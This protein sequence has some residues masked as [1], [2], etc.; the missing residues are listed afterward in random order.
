MKKMQRFISGVLSLLIICLLFVNAVPTVSGAEAEKGNWKTFEELTKE[1]G[2]INGIQQP[3]FIQSSTG[4]D[5]GK[6]I[7]DGYSK[8]NFNESMFYEVFTNSKAMGFEICKLWLTYQFGGILFDDDC[9]VVGVEPTYLKNLPRVFEIAEEC[10]IYLCITLVNHFENATYV[11]GKY[12]HEEI[13]Q[14]VYNENETELFIENFA[15]PILNITKDFPNIIMCDIFCEPESNGGRWGLQI[16]TSWNNIVK[17]MT[18]LNKTV[19]QVNPRL[20]TFSSASITINNITEGYYDDIGL[21]CYGFDYYSSYGTAHKTES[22]FLDAP[23]V[24]GEVGTNSTNESEEYMSGF[25]SNY[26]ETAAESGVKA[27]FYWLYGFPTTKLQSVVDSS[28]RL[29]SFTLA[30]RSSALDNEYA[31]TG[32]KGIDKPA[33]MYSTSDYIRWYGSRGAVRNTLQRSEDGVNWKDIVSFDPNDSTAAADYEFSAMMYEYSDET[34]AQG[35]TYYYHAAAEDENG[36]ICVSDAVKVTTEVY[37]CSEEDNLIKNGGFE[38]ATL[39]TDAGG[40]KLEDQ[41]APFN[42]VHYTDGTAGD[43]T[44]SGSGSVY[45]VT[46]IWQPVNLKPNTNYTLTFYY[47]YDEVEGYWGSFCGTLVN[48]PG[49]GDPLNYYGGPIE[50]IQPPDKNKD[51]KWHRYTVRF[52]SKNYTKIDVAFSAWH[53]GATGTDETQIIDWYIDDV[54]LFESK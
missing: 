34:L 32:Y 31:R 28:G 12:T 52:N 4:N 11:N 38:A 27:G 7:M 35:K 50:R 9:H 15:K 8:T 6:S 20:V 18:K 43:T 42:I 37:T 30:F 23:L 10:G 3:W 53:G 48:Y 36:K 54:Y 33:M 1:K 29:R 39:M 26:L 5:I 14:F 44:N 17:F 19:K 25:V 13:S 40:W 49:E 51:G 24:Y 46:R 2:F 16:G 47:R 45:K 41:P 21:D 22:L